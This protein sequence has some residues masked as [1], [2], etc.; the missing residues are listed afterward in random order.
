[1]MGFAKGS[2]TLQPICAKQPGKGGTIVVSKAS[3]AV[4]GGKIVGN[5]AANMDFPAPGVPIINT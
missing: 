5:R 1:M 3:C 2:H 4:M